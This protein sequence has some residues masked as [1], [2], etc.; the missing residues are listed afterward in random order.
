MYYSLGL[1][2]YDGPGSNGRMIVDWSSDVEELEVAR[3]KGGAWYL[4][5]FVPMSLE[6]AGSWYR[7]DRFYDVRLTPGVW[8]GRLTSVRL[9]PG[10]IE[11]VAKGY[12]RALR[13]TTYTA[14]WSLEGPAPWRPLD[15]NDISNAAPE[16]YYMDFTNRIY[17]A[18][19]KNASLDSTHWAGV[20]Y[21]RPDNSSVDMFRVTFDYELLGPTGS[22]YRGEFRQRQYDWNNIAPSLWTLA[23]DGTVQTGSQ[24]ITVS[25]GAVA[26]SFM[27][28]RANATPEVYTGETG[29]FYLKITN[30]RIYGRNGTEVREI[31][32]ASC[33]ERV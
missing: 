5:G 27:L 21:R 23:T 22:A 15:Q 19:N 16:R 12:Y 25:G 8:S 32:R 1:Q 17:I 31:G 20:G 18:A 3:G 2:V 28:Y 14:F 13:D 9:V 24:D 11:F 10:G 26:F 29:D 7:M 4:S 6:E 30:L 33:R